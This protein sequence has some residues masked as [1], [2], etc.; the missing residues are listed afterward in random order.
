M[1]ESKVLEAT[2]MFVKV[3]LKIQFFYTKKSHMSMLH[4]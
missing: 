4:F 1:K 3:L 2:G